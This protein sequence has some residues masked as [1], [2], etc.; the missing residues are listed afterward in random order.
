MFKPLQFS[1]KAFNAFS[2]VALFQSFVAVTMQCVLHCRLPSPLQWIFQFPAVSMCDGQWNA[3]SIRNFVEMAWNEH[4]LNVHFHQLVIETNTF[5]NRSR[6][7]LQLKIF[8]DIEMQQQLVTMA[9][10]RYALKHQHIR[11][12][13]KR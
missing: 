6:Q 9:M 7:C 3:Y 2:C 1:N 12:F 5:F 11:A 8:K 10:L 13:N 4:Y